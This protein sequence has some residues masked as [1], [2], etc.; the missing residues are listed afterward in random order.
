MSTH[1]RN[2]WVTLAMLLLISLQMG[3]SNAFIID[4]THTPWLSAA[5]GSRTGN[6]TAGIL[7]WSIVPNGTQISDTGQSLGDSDLITYLNETFE[8]DPSE[9]DLT[10]QPWFSIFED[11]FNRWAELSGL[12]FVFEPNDDGGIHHTQSGVL[13]VRGDIRIG[14]VSIDGPGNTLAFNYFPEF[15]GDMVLD[16]DETGFARSQN[17]H[18]FLRN[19]VMHELG[20][21]FGLSHVRSN[22]DRLL[23]EAF[24]DEQI[25]GPQLDE[26][27]GI[28]YFF[29]DRFEATNDG[30]GNGATTLATDLGELAIAGTITVGADGNRPSQAIDNE[31]TDFVSISNGQDLDFYSVNIAHRGNLSVALTPLGGTFS[32]SGDGGRPAP[33]DADARSNLSLSLV[34]AAGTTIALV[35]DTDAGEVEQIDSLTVEPGTYFARISGDAD[36]SIQL[37]MLELSFSA[38]PGDCNGDGVVDQQDLDCACAAGLS[39]VLGVLEVPRGDLDLDGSVQ[40]GDFLI[41][42]RNFGT[43][44]SYAEGDVDCSGD[45]A[46]ADFVFLANNYETATATSALVPEP[47]GLFAGCG[48]LVLLC[49][50]GRRRRMQDF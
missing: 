27:R 45:I 12:T 50:H 42:S 8:G 18:L 9:A 35:D 41:L 33:F 43:E 19:T 15:G 17:D 32:Q 7:T 29:G 46:F 21:A 37:Y 24:T 10:K 40:F 2:R 26:V 13:G 22:T 3:K 39:E 5:S 14:G 44:G 38:G 20:H 28:Q 47:N 36:D 49:G 23:M 34:D 31:L 11:S 16:T 4:P 25:D 48:L 1:A 30:Q 6:G